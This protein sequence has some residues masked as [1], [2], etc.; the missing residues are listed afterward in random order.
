[1]VRVWCFSEF[2]GSFF[3]FLPI[4]K[5]L[6]CRQIRE[7]MVKSISLFWVSKTFEFSFILSKKENSTFLNRKKTRNVRFRKYISWKRSFISYNWVL[8]RTSKNASHTC[9]K[10]PQ[11]GSK[12][13]TIIN[14]DSFV[15]D[16]LGLCEHRSHAHETDEIH[17]RRIG[18]IRSAHKNYNW[19]LCFSEYL[20][21]K[22]MFG[23]R[24]TL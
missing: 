14:L 3:I 12:H 16:K 24:R 6:D 20:Q 17:C 1:M 22:Q 8:M 9:E 11:T 5:Q 2:F 18:S 19:K 23:T 4:C 21:W 15:S 13:S 7:K 10:K